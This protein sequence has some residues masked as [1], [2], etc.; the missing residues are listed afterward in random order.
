M[1][2][3]RYQQI[4]SNIIAKLIFVYEKTQLKNILRIFV[5]GFDCLFN[6][7]NNN[8]K[9]YKHS[10]QMSPAYLIC[11]IHKNGTIQS[12]WFMVY[13][14]K[15]LKVQKAYQLIEYHKRKC[16]N[17][18]FL[19]LNECPDNRIMPIRIS[20]SFS[21][22]MHTFLFIHRHRAEEKKHTQCPK[23]IHISVVILYVCKYFWTVF[24]FHFDVA[25]MYIFAYYNSQ[26]VV[27]LFARFHARFH[28]RLRSHLFLQIDCIHF[29]SHF[30]S[31]FCHLST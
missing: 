31:L 26:M 18:I 9:Y 22:Y 17:S 2:R 4:T 6:S 16:R 10:I 28:A 27:R 12:E 24:L 29:I 15:H 8:S 11:Q 30:F 7:I 20:D 13:G 21:Y 14:T 25:P 5:R 3:I 1:Y 23:T 19:L